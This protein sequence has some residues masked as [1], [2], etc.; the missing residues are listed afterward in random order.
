MYLATSRDQRQLFVTGH[1]EYERGTLAA[2]YERDVAKGLPIKVPVNYFPNDDPTRT[3]LVT[4]RSHAFLLYSNWLN[5]YVYQRTPYDLSAIPAPTAP[6]ED[7]PGDG[8]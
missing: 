6:A 4:W 3:P 8:A 5:Y 7:A 1:P 2:E